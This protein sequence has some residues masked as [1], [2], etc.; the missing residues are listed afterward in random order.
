MIPILWVVIIVVIAILQLSQA[1]SSTELKGAPFENEKPRD[2]RVDPVQRPNTPRP[3]PRP[4]ELAVADLPDPAPKAEAGNAEPTTVQAASS[5][6]LMQ[7]IVLSEILGPPRA[8]Q[9]RRRQ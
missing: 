2:I 3:R 7:A 6:N 1:K 4:V 8:K 5:V 9:K